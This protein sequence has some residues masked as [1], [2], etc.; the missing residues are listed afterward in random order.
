MSQ[1]NK[2]LTREITVSHHFRDGKERCICRKNLMN[3][4]SRS[5][6]TEP[7]YVLYVCFPSFHAV[8]SSVEITTDHD[9]FKVK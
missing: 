6:V 4:L 5:V 8:K 7:S 1:G 2:K 3:G 9:I